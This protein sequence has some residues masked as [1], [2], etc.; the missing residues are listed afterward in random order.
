MPAKDVRVREVRINLDKQRTLRFDM[1][2][3]IE[4]EEVYGNINKAFEDMKKGKIK[5]LRAFL[6]AGLKHEDE[7]LTVQGIGRMIGASDFD[8]LADQI[9]ASIDES[10]PEDD[11]LGNGVTQPM[12][13]KE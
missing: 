3:F 12:E 10:L 4:L 7:S 2:A 9:I 13:N 5:A 8:S 1:N 11:G 6:Y